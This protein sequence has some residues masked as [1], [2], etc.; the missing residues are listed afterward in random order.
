[1]Q[2]KTRAL[3]HEVVHL[4]A[5]ADVDYESIGCSSSDSDI[6]AYWRPEFGNN[7]VIFR[8]KHLSWLSVWE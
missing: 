5:P 7:P 1:M 4:P 8:L 6:G 2:I 3:R